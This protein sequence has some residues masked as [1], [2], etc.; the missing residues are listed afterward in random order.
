MVDLCSEVN[1][2]KIIK[3]CPRTAFTIKCPPLCCHIH[4]DI[5]VSLPHQS[6]A[7]S[8]NSQEY[9]ARLIYTKC[10]ITFRR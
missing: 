9:L 4:T 5:S 1:H 8:T 7:T 6:A 3:N 10:L 2:L